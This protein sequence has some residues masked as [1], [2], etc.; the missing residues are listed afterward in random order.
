MARNDRL[1]SALHAAN[2][3]VTTFSAQVG[4]DPK[5][6]ERW[7]N[8]GRRPQSLHRRRAAEV[9]DV[10]EGLLWPPTADDPH[11]MSATRA[12]LVDIYANR[13][14]VPIDLWTSL[15]DSSEERIDLLAFAASF[16]HDSIPDFLDRL[17][18]RAAAGVSVRLLFGDPSS[19]AVAT[20]GA[21]EAIGDLMAARCRLTWAYLDPILSAPGVQARAHG[22]TLY[23]S[24]FR[25]DDTLLV[26]PHV[27][28]VAAGHSPVLHLNR[29]AGGRLVKHYSE[30]FD[31]VW[32]HSSAVDSESETAS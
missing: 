9:L 22:T 18:A 28:G 20:R 19:E 10:E 3:T 15:I 16:M 24:L 17:R 27:F 26:N 8:T 29:L 30:T 32:E 13:G 1:R 5:T 7:I 2:L 12:E 14:T 21:E 6:V 25:F 31:R 11:S 23:A 4:V